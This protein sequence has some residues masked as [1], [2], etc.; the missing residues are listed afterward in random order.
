VHPVNSTRAAISSTT[1]NSSHKSFTSQPTPLLA[2][3][4]TFAFQTT[5]GSLHFTLS[6]SPYRTI[7]AYVSLTFLPHVS[8]TQVSGSPVFTGLL[9]SHLTRHLAHF[10]HFTP[11]VSAYSTT[12]RLWVAYL[13]S[14][15]V[16]TSIGIPGVNRLSGYA[17]SDAFYA[18][19]VE[20][21]DAE[22][23]CK[24]E[25]AKRCE[26]EVGIAHDV[27]AWLTC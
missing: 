18:L 13:F 22:G 6:V 2:A 24:S 1:S 19:Q 16:N 8:E 9:T 5:S 25:A 21:R 26:R 12:P 20:P 14:T 10:S 23:T 3:S 15:C 27:N 17:L 11:S 7:H 4:A